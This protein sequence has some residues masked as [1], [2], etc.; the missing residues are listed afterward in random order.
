MLVVG[1]QQGQG[2][3][4]SEHGGAAILRVVVFRSRE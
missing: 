4:E 2:L 3:Q 1:K